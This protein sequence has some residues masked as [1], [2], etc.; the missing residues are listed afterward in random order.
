[1]SSS[2]SNSEVERKA[3]KKFLKQTGMSSVIAILC[4][5]IINSTVFNIIEFNDRLRF[6]EEPD[7][8]NRYNDF[9]AGNVNGNYNLVF[10]GT[11][12]VYRQINPVLFDSLTNYRFNSYN[13]A[14]ANLFPFR[15][16][17]YSELILTQNDKID[18][19]VLE[20]AS[21]ATLSEN[22]SSYPIISSMDKN[23]LSI[24]SDFMKR[25]SF[26]ASKYV[27]TYEYY[28][29][30]FWK[31]L[32]PGIG[33][34][35][36]FRNPLGSY[37]ETEIRGHKTL[38]DEL[39]DPRMIERYAQFRKKPD[40]IKDSYDT[41]TLTLTNDLYLRYVFQEVLKYESRFGVKVILFIPPRNGKS[42]SWKQLYSNF[43]R[44]KGI[45]VIDLSG[46]TK[47]PDLYLPQNSFDRTHLN[48][49]GA[50]ILTEKLAQEFNKLN[51]AQ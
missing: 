23:R 32:K 47:Y 6:F 34:C 21:L 19:L 45:Q 41:L 24:A 10:I 36:I 11:S 20:M 37:S 28:S 50:K 48:E 3:L 13:L 35:F 30:F 14:Y 4:I 16:F 49:K 27:D 33:S 5:L 22:S 26:G 40:I 44:E 2:I 25:Y 9:K 1:M 39:K 17:D 7:L 18:V 12:K 8:I 15:M 51:A 38:D 46:E 31:H 43:F 29:A 42:N